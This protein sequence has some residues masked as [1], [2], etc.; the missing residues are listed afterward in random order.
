MN[1]DSKKF[2]KSNIIVTALALVSVGV[3]FVSQ[4]ILAY[5]FGA[6]AERDA[7]FSA[8]VIP[9]Y[10]V[11]LFVGSF[12]VVFLPFYMEFKKKN[13]PLD[14]N[15]VIGSM[16]GLCTALLTCIAVAGF[17]ASGFIVTGIAPGFDH[18]QALITRQLFNILIFS[19]IFQSL[20]SFLTIFHH[21]ESRF[22]LPAISPIITPVISIFFVTTFSEYG[23]RSLAVGTLVG[24]T[25]GVIT[26]LPIVINKIDPGHFFRFIN[27][28]T[29][30]LLKLTVPLFISGSV[31][32]LT[33]VLERIIASKLPS[34]SISYLGYGNQMYL[35]LA[36]IA[37]GSIAT[38]F[39]PLMSEAW[40]EG[41]KSML[42]HYLSKGVRL[43]LF[44][45]LPLASII[46]VLSYPMI[47]IL[48]ERGLFNSDATEAVSRTLAIL[49]GA[50]IFGSL[51]N[52]IV[53]PFYITQ[54]TTT[55][56]VISTVEVIAYLF[57]G[58]FLSLQY[59][60]LGLAAA[61]TVSTGLTILFSVIVLS[62]SKLI[63]FSGLYLDVLKLLVAAVIC[64]LTA[65]ISY[66]ALN[67]LR[68][69][70]IVT[71]AI[72]ALISLL[73]YLVL[74]LYAFKFRDSSNI[75]SLVKSFF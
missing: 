67:L 41:N 32:R 53:K 31:Y 50:F 29:I 33:T 7:Y 28:H 20:S 23:I 51:G 71:T 12:T 52:V 10:I 30:R 70:I 48:F 2:F 60:Y 47:K 4:M 68:M 46:V 1:S 18:E 49:M 69:N 73:A 74:V 25:F 44:I 35:L 37:S 63:S 61:L 62:K 45:T 24:S 22:L 36:S 55:V 57:I 64:G 43:I 59:S 42:N 65:Y 16:L 13:N 56:S 6:N 34:G 58:Y 15:K 9:S 3:S 75:V 40:S 38:T 11:T 39:Y 27:A 19:V 72:S 66:E 26:L 8:I 17:F 14:V 5:Y 21:V 54:K